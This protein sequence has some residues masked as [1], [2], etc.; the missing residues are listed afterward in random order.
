MT[1]SF[2]RIKSKNCYR[3]PRRDFNLS[4]ISLEIRVDPLTG[5]TGRVFD[6]N[7]QVSP[8]PDLSELVQRSKEQFCPFCPENL[9]KSTPLFPEELIPEG[10]IQTG[11]SICIPN[12]LPLD[13]YTGLAIFSPQH[14]I[15]MEALTP[16]IMMPP[17]SAS[18]E[19]I[20]RVFDW[21]SNVR[22]SSINWNY[23]PPAGSSIIHPHLQVNCGELPTNRFR[24]QLEGCRRYFEETGR[25]FWQDFMEAEREQNE[26]HIGEIGTTFW[27]MSYV[28]HGFLP[29][30]F[31]IFTQHHSLTL[32]EHDDLASFVKGLA[33][34]IQYFDSQGL[35]SFNV[36]IFSVREEPGYRVNATICPRLLT[37]AIGN[38][39]NSYMQVLHNEPFSVK[40]PEAV[41][42]R[43]RGF[44]SK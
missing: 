5:Q 23:M 22:Y 31:C 36:T 16:E 39:D 25:D 17:F 34:T 1:I 6:L 24:M 9:E 33:R 14:H 30:V 41:C 21:D 10:K 29:D 3:D 15:P 28:P 13:K 44:F 32:L 7:Y 8:R 20:Q 40:P 19:F 42:Q 18:L 12:L 38:S 35:Y 4:E 26:R 11:D 43:V 37:R 2:E 27:S